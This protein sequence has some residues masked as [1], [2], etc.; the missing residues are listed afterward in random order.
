MGI[1]KMCHNPSRTKMSGPQKKAEK[2]S[3]LEYQRFTE[4]LS[5]ALSVSKQ[6]IQ[7]REAEAEPEPVSRHARYKYVPAKPQS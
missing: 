1:L 4:A 5:S 7:R 2:P 3:P 6:E